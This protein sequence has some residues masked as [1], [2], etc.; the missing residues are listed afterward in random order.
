MDYLTKMYDIIEN[1]W[2]LYNDMPFIYDIKVIYTDKYVFARIISIKYN[3]T[4]KS[5]NNVSDVKI[6]FVYDKL[7]INLL[8]N[9]QNQN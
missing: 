8:Q 5:N 7:K 4:I 1:K 6:T 2:L 9:E 3:C